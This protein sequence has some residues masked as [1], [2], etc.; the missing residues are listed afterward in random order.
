MIRIN[1]IK[2][3]H[4]E[5]MDYSTKA[6]VEFLKKKACRIL[7]IQEINIES[8][9]IVKHS[10]DAR[11]K[12]ELYHI[13]TIDLKVNG[14][15]EEKI[16][17][18]CRDKNVSVVSEKKYDF[19][20]HVPGIVHKEKDLSDK[21]IIIIG[22]G[23]AGLFCGYELAKQGFKPLILERGADV[24][25]RSEIVDKF[26][27]TGELDE[28]TN[29]QFGEGGAGTFSDGKLNT[30]V[31]D[32]ECRG[33]E[34]LDI[35]TDHGAPEQIK[36]E[37]KP[38]IGTDILKSVV[39]NIREDIKSYGGEVYFETKVTELVLSEN[40]SLKGVIAEGADGNKKQIDCDV[41]V[42]AIGHSAR[43]T[44]YMLKDK[45]ADM[46]P[47]PFAVG[48][49]VEHP[50]SL[51]NMSQYGSEHV[52]GL[53]AAPYKL[54]TTT[55][56]GRGVYSFCMCPG[57]YVV[58]AS[59]EKGRLAVNGMSYSGRDGKNANS[60]I[61]ITVDPQD[62]GGSDV[63]SGVEF[64]RRLEEN[65][66]KLAG[67]RIPAEYYGDFKK[68]CGNAEK[69]PDKNYIDAESFNPQT[70]GEYEFA[71]VHTILP[72]E[73]NKAFVEG[74]ENFGRMIRG[75]NDDHALVLG[76]ES[77]TSSPVRITRNDKGESTGIEGLFPCGEG[78]GYAGGI[79]SAAMDGIRSAEWVAEKLLT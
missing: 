65:A 56:S 35:F 26:W 78:A 44:F 16:V 68:A 27:A 79:M 23:P 43:D 55:E 57:G 31:K 3:Q 72:D 75:Y 38:H 51:I 10:L 14:K 77:R 2:I 73:L 52:K 40:G 67:G 8:L 11:K 1:Q 41:A 18:A 59:S 50:Q 12:P 13:Y 33:M 66:Y 47:K 30:M 42:L 62:F 45:N 20:S 74:M 70:K 69:G 58:N 46:Q 15:P 64:Q 54:V 71:D 39:K 48:F 17:K 36:Y 76:V 53:G 5:N 4:D 25:K 34:A 19:W 28:T 21:R 49:R 60:A 7:K 29:V 9:S 61:I 24:D 22:C 32:K 63:L 6:M 37:A